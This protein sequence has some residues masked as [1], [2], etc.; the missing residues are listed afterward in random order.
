MLGTAHKVLPLLGLCAALAGSGGCAEG[1]YVALDARVG[2]SGQQ[3]DT[4]GQV[5]EDGGNPRVDQRLKPP[6][7]QVQ[8]RDTG[9]SSE[10]TVTSPKGG[11]KWAAGTTQTITWTARGFTGNVS[12]ELWTGGSLADTL[13]KNAP[14]TGTYAWTVA[15]AIPGGDSYQIKIFATKDRAIHG[16]SP[17]TFSVV[18][19]RYLRPVVVDA[20]ALSGDL[21]N[22]PV[23]VKLAPGNFDYAHARAGGA[24]LRFSSKSRFD[25]QPNLPCWIEQWNP[26]GTSLV[27]VKV[28]SLPAGAKKTFYLYYGHPTAAS[29]SDAVQTFPRTFV[30]TGEHTLTGTK[31]FDWFELK[32]A[33]TL[34]IKRGAL[35]QIQ[36]RRVILAGKVNGVGQ[37]FAGGASG[38]AGQGSGGGGTSS[39]SGGGGGG[40]A[41]AG[42]Q[43][44]YDSG[45]SPGL[46]G[47]PYGNTTSATIEMG[48]GGGSG[49]PK[50]GG[51]GGGG[52]S[53][54]AEQLH[55]TGSILNDGEGGI[56][57]AQSGGGG[58]G[59]GILLVGQDLY[60]SGTL[61]VRGGDGGSGSD[62]LNDGGGGGAGGRIKVYYSG[63]VSN[64]ATLRTS[65]GAGGRYGGAAYGQAGGGGTSDVL[66]KT[67]T[68]PT[69]SVGSEQAL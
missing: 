34:N 55:L 27:W 31:D 24:D 68:L 69:V 18:N 13:A 12:I 29:V 25:G 51:N 26:T 40:Y 50:R 21:I 46:G 11:V 16:A 59:G 5:W 23:L 49:G 67:N 1:G 66:L 20:T 14:N 63:G 47:K 44:G 30:S 56:G 65:G 9:V 4:G 10:I 36:A 3:Q 41:T 39:D 6:D 60:L 61:S 43:G 52:L 22:Y 19:W 64:T 17:G 8:K 32:A 62:S 37:G 54:L 38:S 35:L 33:H 48:S 42:G 15:Y 53:V 2:D 28:L 58:A 45:D 57:G 7:Q